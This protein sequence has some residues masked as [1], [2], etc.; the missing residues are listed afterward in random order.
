VAAVT[1]IGDQALNDVADKGLHRR[2]YLGECVAIVGI[3]RQSR[4]VGDKLAAL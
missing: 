2:N 1:G 4:D 3:A